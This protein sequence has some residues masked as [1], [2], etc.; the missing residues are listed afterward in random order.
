[1]MNIRAMSS[2]AWKVFNMD[3]KGAPGISGQVHMIMIDV[4]SDDDDVYFEHRS[5]NDLLRL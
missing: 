1:M 2:R 5:I 3:G 4:D